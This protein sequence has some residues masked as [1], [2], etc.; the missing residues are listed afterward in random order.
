[1]RGPDGF[2]VPCDDGEPGEMLGL[3]KDDDPTTKFQGYTDEKASA[4]KIARDVF[5]KGDQ[6]FRTGDLLM[7]D[8]KGY[9]HF[10]D[11]IG[12]TFRWKGENVSTTEVA[13]ALSVFPGALLR[14]SHG[15]REAPSFVVVVCR[16]AATG[17]L[18][19][20]RLCVCVWW[21]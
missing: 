4:K 8:S 11:R 6:Y 14:L 20:I 19:R 17:S 2:C 10:V 9:F 5:V 1:M 13:E 12:D 15:L 16:A 18:D 7:R 21:W 3:I